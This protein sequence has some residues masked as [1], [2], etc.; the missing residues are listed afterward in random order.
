MMG[1]ALWWLPISLLVACGSAQRQTEA[2]ATVVEME[3]VIIE[4]TRGQ[5]GESSITAFDAQQLFE[6]GEADFKAT[7]FAE[8]DAQY[9]QLLKRFPQSRYVHATLYNRGLCLEE[10]GQHALAG[11]HFRRHAEL[12]KTLNDRRDGE[13]R[14]GYNLVKTGDFPTALALY[15][16]LLGE[17]DLTPLDRAECLLRQ[18][19]AQVGISR[20]GQA[21]K[22]LEAAIEHVVTGTEGLTKGNDTLAEVYF[23]RG[24]IYQ[25]L[26]HEVPL[27]LPI[28]QMQDDLAD[29]VRFFR[30][31]QRGYLDALNVQ[32]PYWATAA[33]LKLGE[34]YEAFYRDVLNAQ[35]PDDFDEK[36]SL[37]YVAELRKKLQ[38]LLEHSLSI[39]ERNITMSQRIG[40]ENEWVTETESRLARLRTL[41]EETERLDP[42]K[43]LEAGPAEPTEVPKPPSR[44]TSKPAPTGTLEAVGGQG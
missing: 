35:M 34:L 3:P 7:R 8:C 43:A 4:L 1:R 16:R 23:V 22:S 42:A 41:I 2:Q 5:D 32:H 38:P 15:G 9:A 14:W 29:K 31:A 6:A 30:R 18:A 39:Y 36:T 10:L 26:A 24:T 20:L 17:T 13:F 12:S 40:A 11:R 28:E 25:R 19:M 27:K 21:E 33:G 44:G 37:F